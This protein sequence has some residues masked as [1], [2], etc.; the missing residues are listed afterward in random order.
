MTTR[1]ARWL[2]TAV[3]AG[4]SGM[5]SATATP[6]DL[7]TVSGVPGTGGD[8]GVS[9]PC[10]CAQPAYFSPVM[11][12]TPGTYDF[13][14]VRDYWVKADQTPDG[15]PDQENLYVLFAP[16]VVTGVW[17]QDYPGF[18]G[19]AYPAYVLCEQG[20]DACNASFTG[21]FVDL[22]LVFTLPSGQD[23]MQVG[24][25]GDFRY[26]PPVPEPASVALMLLGVVC[27]ATMARRSRHARA[28]SGLA[29]P[30]PATFKT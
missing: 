5:A 6:I 9:G 2:A 12:L 4:A 26:T 8:T 24:L 27:I 16:V 28:G 18:E 21:R 15:G 23:A 30:D 1:L 25:V 7:Y 14:R 29:R 10:Y 22:S 11:L 3:V 13:G 19:Y 17:P 20:D